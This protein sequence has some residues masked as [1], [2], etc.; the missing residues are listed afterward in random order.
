[1]YREIYS[2]S[3]SLSLSLSRSL[4]SSC[5][6]SS[7]S[8]P[9]SSYLFFGETE[10]EFRAW[11][12]LYCL[13]HASSPFCCGYFG[14]GVSWTICLCWPWTT[15]LPI[16]AFQVARLLGLQVWAI[17]AGFHFFCFC[18]FEIG[19]YSVA[20]V[21]LEFAILLPWPPVSWDYRLVPWELAKD[22]FK[23]KTWRVEK[24]L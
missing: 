16:S 6:L 3:L 1:M 8:L 7:L 20:Q 23:S 17:G 2:L 10:F 21:G 5:S 13:S 11:K 18:F 4:C 22:L 14:D 24:Y 9:P 12:M 19:S 15:I